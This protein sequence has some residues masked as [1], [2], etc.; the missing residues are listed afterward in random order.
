[1]RF[2]NIALL[3]MVVASLLGCATIRQGDSTE[4]KAALIQDQVKKTGSLRVSA[5]ATAS[6]GGLFVLMGANLPAES[7]GSLA[8]QGD[9]RATMLGLGTLFGLAGTVFAISLMANEQAVLDMQADFNQALLKSLA[10]GRQ[11]REVP[12]P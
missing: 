9:A 2:G 5:V 1:M 12:S 8:D 11:P 10:E 7:S 6:A 3:A 4:T